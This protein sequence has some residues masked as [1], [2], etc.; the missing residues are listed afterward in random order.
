MQPSD[1]P[2]PLH[3][4]SIPCHCPL[5][6]ATVA[7]PAAPPSPRCLRLLRGG[8][9]RM[10]YAANCP[11]DCTYRRTRSPT[12]RP[13]PP[14]SMCVLGECSGTSIPRRVVVLRPSPCLGQATRRGG[15]TG[16]AQARR[17]RNWPLPGLITILGCRLAGT[18]RPLLCAAS[19]G[20]RL[21]NACCERLFQVF[22]VFQG[23]VVSV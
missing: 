9:L 5:R 11:T 20:R 13:L 19:Y 16:Q 8:V 10:R 1:H 17:R 7:L 14:S 21:K 18:D 4:A 22:Q 6:R 3:A 15:V 2:N 23:Y 12:P